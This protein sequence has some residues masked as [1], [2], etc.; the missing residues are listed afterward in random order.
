M[1]FFASWP[2]TM[3]RLRYGISAA[4]NTLQSEVHLA[5]QLI[6]KQ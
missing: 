6:G 3:Y 4:L 1:T 2:L 5:T